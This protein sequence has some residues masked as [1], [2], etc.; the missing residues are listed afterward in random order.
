MLG[1]KLGF[2]RK[3]RSILL[4]PL[5]AFVLLS[6]PT[7]R[8][9]QDVCDQCPPTCPMHRAVKPQR[10]KPSCHNQGSMHMQHEESAKAASGTALSRPPCGH[11]GMVPGVAMG[12]MILMDGI[13][14]RVPLP[15]GSLSPR[16]NRL[17]IRFNE[18]PTPPP[19]IVAS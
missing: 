15:A 11:S 19:P 6:A 1:K 8:A 10:S 5:V 2:G 12:P 18:P 17:Q 7:I 13:S 14:T 9:M 3:A 16:Q 4:S